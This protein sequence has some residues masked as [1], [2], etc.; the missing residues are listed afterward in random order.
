M[1]SCNAVAATEL[2]EFTEQSGYSF[3]NRSVNVFFGAV[4]EEYIIVPF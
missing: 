2:S 4:Y 1:L 3:K